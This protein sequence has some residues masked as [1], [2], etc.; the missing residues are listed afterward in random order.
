MDKKQ[1]LQMH[2]KVKTVKKKKDPREI[3]R[4]KTK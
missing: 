4:D 2:V 1:D 3:E